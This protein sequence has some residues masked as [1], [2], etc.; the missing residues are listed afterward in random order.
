MKKLSTLVFFYLLFFSIW[1]FYRLEGFQVSKIKRP[2]Y[3]GQE[4]VSDIDSEEVKHIL[5]KEF[6]YLGRGRQCFVFESEDKDYVIKFLNYR[7]FNLPLMLNLFTFIPHLKKIAEKRSL[8]LQPSFISYKL[9]QSFL[10]EETGIIYT[11]MQNSSFNKIIKLKDKANIVHKVDLYDV[12]YVVQRKAEPIF[13]HLK[14]L[15]R[16]D[17]EKFKA[18]VSSFLEVVASRIKKN[19][20][21]EDTDVEIN[22]GFYNNKAILIDPG[23]IHVDSRLSN[24]ENRE[25]EMHKSI[26]NF[27][28]WILDK[29]PEMLSFFDQELALKVGV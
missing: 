23:R 15:Y 13:K 29:Y 27:R 16:Q 5:D 1:S 3:V 12:D 25:K 18:A 14:T 22:Y 9:A 6:F 7:R 17:K 19:I 20:I 28:E 8:R 21:D 24:K 10:K 2:Q 26:K 11:Q 4:I